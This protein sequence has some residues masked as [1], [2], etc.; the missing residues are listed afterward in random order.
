MSFFNENGYQSNSQPQA[1]KHLEAASK[2]LGNM[3][4]LS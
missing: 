2:R 3:F 1:A 4:F